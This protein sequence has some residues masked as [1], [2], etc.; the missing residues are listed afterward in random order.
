MEREAQK[1]NGKVHKSSGK[2]CWCE[3]GRPTSWKC[4]L[5]VE[6]NY[7]SAARTFVQWD[8]EARLPGL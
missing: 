5:L 7:G 1:V 8:S 2:V 4:P 6:E 3:S